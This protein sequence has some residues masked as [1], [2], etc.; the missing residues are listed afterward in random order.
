[1]DPEVRQVRRE[2][3]NQWLPEWLAPEDFCNFVATPHI[4]TMA[5]KRR[6]PEIELALVSGNANLDCSVRARC[7]QFG[8]GM[9]IWDP[10]VSS[11]NRASWA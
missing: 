6:N 7:A 5:H 1:M 10:G 8:M 11:Q 3:G 9:Q 4:E 2:F